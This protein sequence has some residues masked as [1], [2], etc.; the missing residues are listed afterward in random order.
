MIRLESSDYDRILPLLDHPT[1]ALEPRSV[2]LGQSPGRILSEERLEPTYALVHV[3]GMAGYY[4]AAKNPPASIDDIRFSLS[5]E[6]T[7]EDVEYL[8]ISACDP[9]LDETI[10]RVLGN[11]AQKSTNLIH[12]L[13][14]LQPPTTDLAHTVPINRNLLENPTF[15]LSP[16][17]DTVSRYWTNMDAFL[18]L[19]V[20]ACVNH[21]GKTAVFCLSAF[22]VDDVHLLDIETSAPLRQR[23]SVG[24]PVA[25][26]FSPSSNAVIRSSGVVCNPTPDPVGSSRDMGESASK[27]TRYTSVGPLT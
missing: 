25:R 12:R 14:S 15:D 20:G 18:D 22:V 6:T 16:I 17:V 4:L 3:I 7:T 1:L 24:P 10:A 2:A 21:E 26:A 13:S 27:S 11:R 5:Q 9:G 8:E 19:G 23:V